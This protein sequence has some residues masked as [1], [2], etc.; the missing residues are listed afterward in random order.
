MKTLGPEAGTPF[1]V[2]LTE[3]LKDLSRDGDATLDLAWNYAQAA[4]I[5]QANIY[6]RVARHVRARN[7]GWRIDYQMVT[8]NLN[9]KLIR[10]VLLPEAV[11]S[12]HC[13]MLLEIDF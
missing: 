1:A 13:A 9:D 5:D 3:M 12:D 8:E 7:L 4:A 11:H 6:A 2:R 10:A